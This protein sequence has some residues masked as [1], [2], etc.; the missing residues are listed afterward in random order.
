MRE[1]LLCDGRSGRRR[2][3][4]GVANVNG[5]SD[6][7]G[8]WDSVSEIARAIGNGGLPVRSSPWSRR[9]YRRVD[10]SLRLRATPQEHDLDM[11]G[12]TTDWRVPGA[13]GET[14]RFQGVG[15]SPRSDPCAAAFF[16]G[17]GLMRAGLDRCSI[18]AVFAND[19]DDAK[20][21]I[22]RGGAEAPDEAKTT[23]DLSQVPRHHA[24]PRSV[25]LRGRVEGRNE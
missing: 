4:P 8:V 6:T 1:P 22:Y 11:I 2:F 15:G 12:Q 14:V 24:E 13:G 25:R 10:P 21:A 9:A 23:E 19:M 20:A 5:R 17:M 3:P 16:A 7:L 18:D